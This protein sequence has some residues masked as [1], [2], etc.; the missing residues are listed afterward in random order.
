[1]LAGDALVAKGADNDA[2]PLRKRAA[3]AM[4]GDKAILVECTWQHPVSAETQPVEPVGGIR[5]FVARCPN[6]KF[7]RALPPE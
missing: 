1:M 3:Q 2:V 4:A 6:A 5:A 7:A